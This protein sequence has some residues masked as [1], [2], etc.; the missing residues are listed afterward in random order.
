MQDNRPFVRSLFAVVAARP[1]LTTLLGA[2]SISFSGVLYLY[3]GTSPET[4]AVFR[5]LYGLPILIAVA[6]VER[7]HTRMRRRFDRP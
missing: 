2:I 5:C 4:A 7:R 3:S 6:L 1:R